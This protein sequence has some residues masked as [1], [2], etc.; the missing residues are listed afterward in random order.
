MEL[1]RIFLIIIVLIIFS[2]V[3]HTLLKDRATIIKENMQIAEGMSVKDEIHSL[4]GINQA[5]TIR[6]MNDK[7][8]SIE[9]F[10]TT[11]TKVDIITKPNDDK[12]KKKIFE[13]NT[14]LNSIT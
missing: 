9:D 11:K 12:K 4:L 10:I 3:L 5:I 2:Y 7:P 13:Y 8:F 1:S 6:N 14:Y